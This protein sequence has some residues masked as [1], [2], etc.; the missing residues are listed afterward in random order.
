MGN[1]LTL[2]TGSTLTVG[3]AGQTVDVGNN[4]TATSKGEILQTGTG[5][6]LAVGGIAQLTA[7]NLAL[8]DQDITLANATNDFGTVNIVNA[9]DVRLRDSDGSIGIQGNI[10]GILDIRADGTNAGGYVITNPAELI[11]MGTGADQFR[12]SYGE[13]TLCV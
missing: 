5:S 3:G 6:T 12:G 8:V 13:C 2:D 1:N 11:L 4:L 9:R 10:S 7:Q